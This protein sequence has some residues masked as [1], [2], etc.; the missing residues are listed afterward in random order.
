MIIIIDAYN[1]LKQAL[2]A[3][4]ISEIERLR[5]IKQV[6]LYGKAKG[7]SMIVVFDGGPHKRPNQDRMHGV[8]V[9]YSGTDESADTYIQN[10]LQKQRSLDVLLVSSD[11]QVCLWATDRNIPSL[12]AIDF[13]RLLQESLK[14]S[15]EQRV[16]NKGHQTIKTTQGTVTEL[17][18]LMYETSVEYKKEEGQQERI[19]PGYHPTKHE[20]HIIKKI[21]K[22]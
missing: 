6:G 15:R 17:D 5:F 20:R 22:L 4:H 7:H 14:G 2:P 13:Y 16:H 8:S 1:V 12:E 11:R 21:K 9:V 19:S 18:R 3:D 10:Y